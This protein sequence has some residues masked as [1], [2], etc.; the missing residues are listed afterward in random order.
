[1]GFIGA[2]VAFIQWLLWARPSSSASGVGGADA[3]ICLVVLAGGCL[4][5]VS[6]ATG[7]VYCLMCVAFWALQGVL[8]LELIIS[9]RPMAMYGAASAVVAFA[10]PL[11]VITMPDAKAM[12]S[13][14][15]PI[16]RVAKSGPAVGRK[17]PVKS[18][19]QNGYALI[20][21]N[22]PP[23]FDLTV[24]KTLQLLS[25]QSMPYFVLTDPSMTARLKQIGVVRWSVLEENDFRKLSVPRSSSPLVIEIKDRV[26]TRVDRVADFNAAQRRSAS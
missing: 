16:E 15:V 1:M 26:V 20:V 22:C 19:L 14:Y 17:F 6:L 10:P 3:V 4:A 13:Q 21:T 8:A 11:A 18:E 23:C 9:K 12:L 24:S 2:L 7:L 25:K 5:A